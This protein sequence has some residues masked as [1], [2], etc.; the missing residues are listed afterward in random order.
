MVFES[1]SILRIAVLSG[2]DS[3]E[4]DVKLAQRCRGRRGTG[5]GRP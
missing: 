1:A 5:R 2:G 3:A 4:R